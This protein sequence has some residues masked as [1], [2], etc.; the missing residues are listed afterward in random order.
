MPR[1]EKETA[2]EGRGHHELPWGG[3]GPAI[4]SDKPGKSPH[5]GG[6]GG[7]FRR[8]GGGVNTWGRGESGIREQRT[9]GERKR[10]GERV[11]APV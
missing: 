6:R 5:N 9:V 8:E 10:V 2:A 11:C 3:G 1:V 4:L 7:D